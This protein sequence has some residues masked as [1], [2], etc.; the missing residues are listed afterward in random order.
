MINNEVFNTLFGVV[1]I[2]VMYFYVKN[3][4]NNVKNRNTKLKN[5]G[6]CL[7]SLFVLIDMFDMYSVYTLANGLIIMLLS[8][9]II[10][11]LVPHEDL[12][13]GYAMNKD[14]S[15]ND[16]SEINNLVPMQ[17][18]ID[19]NKQTK[20]FNKFGGFSDFID[21]VND[22]ALIL[23]ILYILVFVSSP[24]LHFMFGGTDQMAMAIQ[25]IN[26]HLGGLNQSKFKTV[27]WKLYIKTY[28]LIIV[29]CGIILKLT[30]KYSAK[31]S[32]IELRASPIDESISKRYNYTLIPNGYAKTILQV[33]KFCLKRCSNNNINSENKIIEAINKITPLKINEVVVDCKYKNYEHYVFVLTDNEQSLYKL[34]EKIKQDENDD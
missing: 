22:L 12:T 5:V 17:I 30:E 8:I 34:N 16:R 24:I 19:S 25:K 9:F 20:K 2:V 15:T 32:L 1:F 4:A 10:F 23:L 6:L 28:G 33:N 31:N 11:N 7:I 29:T 3:E 18:L 21:N 26:P 14:S 27:D 13:P